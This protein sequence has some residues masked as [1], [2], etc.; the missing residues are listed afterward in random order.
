MKKIKK[1]FF[2][3]GFT[4]K[5]ASQER[6]SDFSFASERWEKTQSSGF[7]LIELLVVIAIIGVLSAVVLASLNTAR[8]K[9]RDA[10]RIVNVNQIATAIALYESDNNGVPP[11]E[12]GVEY[13]NGN[14]NWIPGLAPKYIS[15]VPSDPLDVE[16][17]KFHYSRNGK[18]YEVA[19]FLE[20]DGNQ[21]AS[22]DGG[23]S[24]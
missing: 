5:G 11:G 8:E 17:H 15:S 9:A 3:R 2:D 7:T 1:V 16:E 23:S 14:P 10:Q 21:A 24:S 19:S 20:Q 4:T 12:S 18:D 13:V 22:G 6:N